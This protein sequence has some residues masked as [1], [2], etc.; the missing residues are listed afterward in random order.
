MWVGVVTYE[1]NHRPHEPHRDS[2]ASRA[3]AARE[4]RRRAALRAGRRPPGQAARR[5]A[6]PVGLGGHHLLWAGD[7]WACAM[8]RRRSAKWDAIAPKR[9]E[10][11]AAVLW[12]KRAAAVAGRGG[13]DGGGHRRMMSA[14]V[15]WCDRCGAYATSASKGLTQ[16]CPGVPS[17]WTGGGRPQQLAALRAGRHPKTGAWLGLPCPEPR[18]DALPGDVGG[19]RALPCIAAG[20]IEQRRPCHD[21]AALAVPPALEAQGLAQAPPAARSGFSVHCTASGAGRRDAM[22]ARVRARQGRPAGAADASG[23]AALA[24]CAAVTVAPSGAAAST[25]RGC[26]HGCVQVRPAGPPAGA[27]CSGRTSLCAGDLVLG[28]ALVRRRCRTKGLPCAWR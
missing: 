1:A 28:S 24:L 19:A 4:A 17:D 13:R 11:S 21:R 14:D 20:F 2:E 8:C 3:A 25:H 27:G 6:R 26:G 12:A 10:G 16:Q 23:G 18:W 9:C 15:I 5:E 22:Y 7:A